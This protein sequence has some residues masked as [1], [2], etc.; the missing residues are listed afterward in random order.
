[1]AKYL[2]KRF[3]RELA[4]STSV[5]VV[6][7][8]VMYIFQEYNKTKTPVN[9]ALKKSYNKIFEDNWNSNWDK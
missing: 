8:F 3:L 4:L 7:G 9:N 5:G 1:M 2:N 6:S